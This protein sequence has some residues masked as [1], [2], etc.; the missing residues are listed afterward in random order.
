MRELRV[1]L[2]DRRLEVSQQHKGQ[3]RVE[4]RRLIAGDNRYVRRRVPV[5]Q[6][7]EMDL[8]RG[9]DVLIVRRVDKLSLACP[10]EPGLMG[11]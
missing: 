8:G 6:F 4:L 5:E 2:V 11:V 10:I 9:R 1:E 7:I 3:H